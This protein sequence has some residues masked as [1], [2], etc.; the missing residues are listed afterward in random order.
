MLYSSEARSFYLLG[1]SSMQSYSA[2]DNCSLQIG[3]A[4]PESFACSDTALVLPTATLDLASPE[5]AGVL[6]SVNGPGRYTY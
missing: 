1:S 3:S 2:D 4:S 6:D 5:Q